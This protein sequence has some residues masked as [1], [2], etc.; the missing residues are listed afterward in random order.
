MVDLPRRRI[1]PAV[2]YGLLVVLAATHRIPRGDS[3]SVLKIAGGSAPSINLPKGCAGHPKGWAMSLK[4]LAGLSLR[5]ALDADA[6]RAMQD[7]SYG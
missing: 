5:S 7:L 2:G 1:S 6:G 3:R 4:N